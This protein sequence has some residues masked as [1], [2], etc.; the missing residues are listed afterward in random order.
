[1]ITFY[2]Y[3]PLRDFGVLSLNAFFKLHSSS[4]AT[5]YSLKKK[6]KKKSFWSGST[7]ILALICLELPL[8]TGKYCMDPVHKPS[9]HLLD[10]LG[11]KD[12]TS[13][14]IMS[15]PIGLSTLPSDYFARLSLKLPMFHCYTLSSEEYINIPMGYRFCLSK[16][17]L[18]F[19]NKK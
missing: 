19:L 1:M 16:D 3:F 10:F 11:L 5:V 17:H 15:F 7:Q 9:P 4:F 2:F 13:V 12:W 14:P 8:L 6:K 18:Y